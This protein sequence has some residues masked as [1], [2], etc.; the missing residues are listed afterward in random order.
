MKMFQRGQRI[1]VSHD[2]FGSFPG[3]ITILS[4]NQLA[5]GIVLDEPIAQRL[6]D[7]ALVI[8]GALMVNLEKDGRYLDFFGNEWKIE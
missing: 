3:Q 6:G 8:A 2:R 4:T 7:G 5:V 1:I